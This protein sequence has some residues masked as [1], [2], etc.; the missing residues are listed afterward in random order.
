MPLS[1]GHATAEPTRA[2]AMKVVNP[3][4]VKMMMTMDT[5][6]ILTS[7]KGDGGED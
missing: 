6:T 4:I 2:A 3:R 5:R 7:I 1:V